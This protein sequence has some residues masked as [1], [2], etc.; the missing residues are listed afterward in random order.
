MTILFSLK[1]SQQSNNSPAKPLPSQQQQTQQQNGTATTPNS[2]QMPPMLTS[3][4]PNS[5][6]AQTQAQSTNTNNQQQQQQSHSQSPSPL[7]FNSNP[8][9]TPPLNNNNNNNNNYIASSPKH[10]HHANLASPVSYLG[11]STYVANNQGPQGGNGG[12]NNQQIVATG[13]SGSALGSDSG[14]N[15][16][17]SYPTSNFV[18]FISTNNNVNNNNNTNNSNNVIVNNSL[19][20]KQ[21]STMSIKFS[22]FVQVSFNRN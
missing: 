17:M 6:N 15:S 9:P 18:N 20:D 13:G 7:H 16:N 11:L 3:Y 22:K 19:T 2:A 5:S 21:N 10:N 12:I 14:S 1:Q 8:N 4:P